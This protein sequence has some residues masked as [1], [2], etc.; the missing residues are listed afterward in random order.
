MQKYGKFRLL[1]PHLIWNTVEV[2]ITSVA[3]QALK[4][5]VIA[6]RLRDYKTSFILSSAEHE[7]FSAYKYENAN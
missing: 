3:A 1:L 6:K 7:I 4:A 5:S 2:L